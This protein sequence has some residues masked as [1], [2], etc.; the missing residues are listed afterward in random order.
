MVPEKR[1][2]PVREVIGKCEAAIELPLF[3]HCTFPSDRA[4][5]L[6]DF[7]TQ[8]EKR[9]QNHRQRFARI[10]PTFASR[11]MNNGIAF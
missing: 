8:D 9:N 1:L 4:I 5:S 3:R 6:A 10:N 7:F 11:A 2:D